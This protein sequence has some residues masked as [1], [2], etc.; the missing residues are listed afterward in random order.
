MLER[1]DPVAVIQFFDPADVPKATTVG[2]PQF[3][4]RMRMGTSSVEEAF[5]GWTKV[6]I[7]SMNGLCKRIAW[8]F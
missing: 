3:P 2:P 5:G 4:H 6:R 1:E 7:H 8:L